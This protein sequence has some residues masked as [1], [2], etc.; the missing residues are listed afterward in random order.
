MSRLM[1]YLRW[2]LTFGLIVGVWF[3]TGW[4]T[5]ICLFLLMVRVEIEDWKP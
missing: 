1:V 4:F 3:E 5:A 2:L